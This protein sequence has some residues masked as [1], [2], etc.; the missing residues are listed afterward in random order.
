MKGSRDIVVSRSW[1]WR[2]IWLS[3]GGAIQMWQA[4]ISLF[5]TDVATLPGLFTLFPTHLWQTTLC[6]LI[7]LCSASFLRRLPHMWWRICCFPTAGHIKPLKACQ[8]PRF[9]SQLLLPLYTYTTTS[10]YKNSLM[11]KK[12]L[13]WKVHS[14]KRTC[15]LWDTMKGYVCFHV[16]TMASTCSQASISY[17]T[18]RL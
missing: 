5:F 3:N 18:G 8:V 2:F 12:P 9:P 4:T 7:L 1:P 15:L 11:S 14:D 16:Y 6:G 13:N 10:I 17:V